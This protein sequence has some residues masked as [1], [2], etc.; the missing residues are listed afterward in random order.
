VRCRAALFVLLLTGFL[1]ACG[2][3]VGL[4]PPPPGGA[5]LEPPAAPVSPAADVDAFFDPVREGMTPEGVTRLCD[6]HLAKAERILLDIRAK[7][8]APPS[9]LEYGQTLGKLDDVLLELDTAGAFPY[10]MAVAHPAPEVREAAKACEPKTDRFLTAMWLDADVASVLTAYA[11][12]GEALGGEKAR[13]LEHVLRDFRRNGLDLSPSDQARVRAM[14]EE[15]TQIGQDFMSAIGASRAVVEV[16]AAALE[17]LSPEYKSSH[18]VKPN[19]KV[20]ISTDYPDYFPFVTYSTDRKAS[21]ELYKKFVNRGGIGNVRL[22]ERLLVLRGE[23][24]RMLGYRSWAD[25]AI[26]PRMAKSSDA[27]RAFLGDLDKALEAPAQR[28]LSDFLAMHVKLGGKKTDKLLPPDRYYLED[29]VRAEKFSFDSQALSAFLEIGR[30][31]R[32]LMDIT[33]EMYGLSYERLDEETWHPDVE[34]Y[35]V[36][37]GGVRLGKFYLDLH[38]RADKYKHAAMF[39]IRSAKRLSDG[40]YQTPIAALVCNFPKP[41]EQP[42][43]MSHEDVVTFFH[44]F[45][46]VLHHLL[47]EAELSYFSG[48]STARDFVE[49]PSQMFEEWAWD[50]KVLDRFALHHVTDAKIPDDLFAAMQQARAFGRALSTQRQL[51]LATLDFEYHAREPGFDTTRVLEQIQNQSEAFGYVKGTHFQSSFGHLIS[52]NAGYYGYQWALAISRDILTRFRD[53]GLMNPKTAEAFRREV[54]AKGGAVDESEMIAAF[55]G[56]PPN[57]DAYFRYVRGDD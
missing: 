29:R 46:H 8:G 12:K 25:Y 5:P 36:S 26:E 33:A 14:N 10:L 11:A 24:A 47:T 42:A 4:S 37:S 17:G 34:T 15:M 31:K 48:T 39:T 41:G 21:L 55:L 35:A 40:R 13:F 57:H 50:R 53:E 52:Y 45:G 19:G 32:G 56:R 38:P 23:K 27:V 1:G 9:A 20:D 49:A 18:P 30:V 2:G 7:K 44:E 16:P 54:L 3:G 43:L 22:L 28:E 51:F 6:D